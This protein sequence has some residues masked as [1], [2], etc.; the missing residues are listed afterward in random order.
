MPNA[1]R[2]AGERKKIRAGVATPATSGHCQSTQAALDR[3]GR[4]RGQGDILAQCRQVLA[5]LRLPAG[6]TAVIDG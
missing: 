2:A 1:G 6:T 5:D 4:I 3:D